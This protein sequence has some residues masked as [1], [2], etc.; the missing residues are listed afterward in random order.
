MG[1][2]FTAADSGLRTKIKDVI[3]VFNDF[4]IV[5]DHDQGVAQIPQSM[6]G[7]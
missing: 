1:D 7:R 4:A 6:E 3:A 5:F 2:D